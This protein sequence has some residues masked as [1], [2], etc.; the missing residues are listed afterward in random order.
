MPLSV[1]VEHAE[2][3]T[4]TKFGFEYRENAMLSISCMQNLIND[5]PQ[6]KKL[7]PNSELYHINNH[8]VYAYA[9][10]SMKHFDFNYFMYLVKKFD[11]RGD[12]FMLSYYVLSLL[13]RI[14]VYFI[15][16]K[17]SK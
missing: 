9:S 7:I 8:I 5:N 15:K 10:A 2:Q 14:P 4:K 3:G 16:S 13:L 6:L 11:L 12:F 17:F 1:N